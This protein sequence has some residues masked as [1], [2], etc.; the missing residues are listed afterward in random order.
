MSLQNCANQRAI[1]I[2]PVG[3]KTNDNNIPLKVFETIKAREG[4]KL[5]EEG[6]RIGG[7]IRLGET[8]AKDG[9]AIWVEPAAEISV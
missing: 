5:L 3:P 7:A 9:V 4:K 2:S 8:Q 6:I 1:K